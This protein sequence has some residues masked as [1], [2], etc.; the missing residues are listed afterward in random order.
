MFLAMKR[1]K[2]R[3]KGVLSRLYIRSG[4]NVALVTVIKVKVQKTKKRNVIVSKKE[5]VKHRDTEK[6]EHGEKEVVD[7]RQ[8][9]DVQM[10]TMY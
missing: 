1:A 10:I 8:E 2:E 9:T 5:K 6:W 3:M 7:Q 4:Y